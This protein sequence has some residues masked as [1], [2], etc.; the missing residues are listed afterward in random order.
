MKKWGDLQFALSLGANS[1]YCMGGMSV[2]K[3]V[4]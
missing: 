3:Q 1:T 2:I 4:A